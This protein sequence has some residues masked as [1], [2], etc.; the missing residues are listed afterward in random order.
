MRIVLDAMGGDHAPTVT[1]AAAVDAAR[2]FGVTVVLVGP[3]DIVER[4][5]GKYPTVQGIELVHAAEWI[6]MDEHPATA[7]RAKKRNSMTVGLELIKE[8]RGDAFVTCGHTGAALAASLF[9]LGRIPGIKRPALTTLYPT[10]EGFTLVID[11]GANADCKPEYLQQFAL[12]GSIYAQHA[13]RVETPRVGLLSIG[14]EA[15]KGNQLVRETFPLL[16]GTPG[17]HFVGNVE[18]KEIVQ[19]LVDVVVTDGFTGNVFIKTSEAVAAMLLDFIK[20]SVRGRPMAL[21]G[22]ALARPA[23][24]TVL[25][26][27]DPREYG[28]APL[29]GVRGNVIVGHGRSDAYAV[30]NA[31][32][33]G[34]HAAE[35]QIVQRIASAIN[36]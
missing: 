28:G 3:Q 4:E 1:V 30:R 17:L 32:R 35:G 5:L 8:G 33:M 24:K 14:E 26:R 9:T 18:P 10:R 16:Q 36:V 20:E 12:M 13:L 23:L 27:V 29:L 11:V 6:R 2:H 7:V 19:G 31:I 34:I 15:G 22:M 25:K 21:A